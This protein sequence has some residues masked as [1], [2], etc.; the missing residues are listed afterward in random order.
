MHVCGRRAA[1]APRHTTTAAGT[2]HRCAFHVSYPYC[3]QLHS[4]CSMSDGDAWCAAEWTLCGEGGRSVVLRNNS[5][6]VLRLLKAAPAR[7]D[8]DVHNLDVELWAHHLPRFSNASHVERSWLFAAHV[9]VPLLGRH[10]SAG[11]LVRL[12]AEFVQA[13][14]ARLGS[15]DGALPR[16]LAID[17]SG[18]CLAILLPDNAFLP[19]LPAVCGVPAPV[20]A[21]EIKPKC[22]FLPSVA[23]VDARSAKCRLSRFALHQ[24]LKLAQGKVEEVRRQQALAIR[25]C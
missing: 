21:V 8:A 12:P 10:A 16:A 25:G 1:P 24:R 9:L 17:A 23:T 3:A 15:S 13:V 6:H 22:G 4:E 5:G 20:F 2:P 7:G 14:G 18:G 19:A 11:R